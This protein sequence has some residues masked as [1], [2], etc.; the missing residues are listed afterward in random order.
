M[1]T[2]EEI[3]K[4]H[5]LQSDFEWLKLVRPYLFKSIIKAMDEVRRRCN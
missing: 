3:L 2:A 1:K 5:L 4:K